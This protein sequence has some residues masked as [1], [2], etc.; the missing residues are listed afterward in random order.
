ML[1]S[2]SPRAVRKISRSPVL[3][4]QGR[5]IV[6]PNVPLER[7]AE[8]RPWTSFRLGRAMRGNSR[9]AALIAGPVIILCAF[10]GF[11]SAQS[12]KGF[13]DEFWSNAGN[14]S[15]PSEVPSSTGT[16]IFGLLA[17]PGARVVS[18]LGGVSVGTLQFNAP[19]LVTFD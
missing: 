11:A 3:A 5:L 4:E 7:S 17:A 15:L 6:F 9:I 13:Y 18:T 12:W 2:P 10:P 16:A 8:R 1:T 14:W 19:R